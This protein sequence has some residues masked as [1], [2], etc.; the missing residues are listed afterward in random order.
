MVN[1]GWLPADVAKLLGVT[2]V[3]LYVT[4][5]RVG[6]AIKKEAMRLEAQLEQAAIK[7]QTRLTDPKIDKE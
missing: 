7:N 3:S 1:K 6:A 4:R 5:H 2:L